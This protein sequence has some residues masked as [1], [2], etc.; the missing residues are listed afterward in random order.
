[1]EPRVGARLGRAA[2]GAQRPAS[3]W[4]PRRTPVAIRPKEVR[5]R[6]GSACDS[7]RQDENP[8]SCET[9]CRPTTRAP[10]SS[11]LPGPCDEEVPVLPVASAEDCGMPALQSRTLSKPTLSLS[12]S[13]VRGD[14]LGGQSV[15][16]ESQLGAQR[17]V[18]VAAASQ[19]ALAP[20]GATTAADCAT[21]TRTRQGFVPCS[22]LDQRRLGFGL[23]PTRQ[24]P[25]L[26]AT[27]STKCLSPCTKAG[28]HTMRSVDERVVL[29]VP[30]SFG[31]A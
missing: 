5:E 14:R 22:S 6:R 29:S 8:T 10:P 9:R 28:S 30:M 18:M 16:S 27:R 20:A 23:T 1:M 11:S 13:G 4:Q 7:R 26:S 19:G 3:K 31:G 25:A 17:L 15:R 24:M 21:P 12:W 2:C